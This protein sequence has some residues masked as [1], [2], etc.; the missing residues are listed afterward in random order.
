MHAAICDKRACYNTSTSAL[1]TQNFPRRMYS[2]TCGAAA[3]PP[4]QAGQHEAGTAVAFS[5]RAVLS[6][7]LAF[8]ALPGTGLPAEAV[9]GYTAGRL[10]GM[11]KRSTMLC[12]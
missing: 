12:N 9:Q 4:A 1:H 2:T 3:S 10:P 6:A 11:V 8:A 7:A 5:R